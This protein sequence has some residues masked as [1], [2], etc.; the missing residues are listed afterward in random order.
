MKLLAI[1]EQFDRCE[2]HILAA[3][4]NK[5]ISIH[6]L[7]YGRPDYQ[8]IFKEAGIELISFN[9]SSRLD[10]KAIHKLRFLLR[11]ENFDLA[12]CFSARALSNLL[13]ASWGLRLRIIAYRGTSGHVSRLNPGAWF[14]FLHPRV[15]TIVC[16]SQSVKNYLAEFLPPQKLRVIYKGHN[17]QWYASRTERSL[18]EFNIPPGAFVVALV[19]NMRP[20]KGVRYLIQAL[21]YIPQ[22]LPIHVLLIG[23][24]RDSAVQ[25]EMLKS[26]PRLHFTGFRRNPHEILRHCSCFVMPSTKREGLPKALLE[27]MSVGLCPIVTNVGGMVEVVKDGENGLVV[28]ACNEGALAQ[29]MMTLYQDS[30]LRVQLAVNAAKTIMERFNIETSIEQ[31]Y[32]LYRESERNYGKLCDQLGQSKVKVI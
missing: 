9:C 2:A 15:D 14:S 24:V 17:S 29:A 25:M 1:A 18:T 31:T 4:A 28:P 22:V 6:A 23:E 30:S 8:N 13:F 32:N 27:A 21:S 7:I 11:K 20:V 5:G 12:H 3:L 19:A 16:V 10:L 26:N